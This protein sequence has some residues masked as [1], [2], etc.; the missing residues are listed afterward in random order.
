MVEANPTADE[1]LND[2]AADAGGAPEEDPN[3]YEA[4]GQSDILDEM[5]ALEFTVRD[6][7]DFG[8]HI[9]YNVTGK[10]LQGVFE[11]KR[12][13][14]EFFVLHDALVKRW[15]GIVLPKCPPKKAMGNKEG[16]FLH[17]RR[18]FLERYMK[19]LSRYDFIINS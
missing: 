5:S 17:E 7:H 13:Y 19:K 11:C 14:N 6:P 8:G 18:Y 3:M 1:L 15:P 2:A 4:K 12:R 16:T 10:D 9:V